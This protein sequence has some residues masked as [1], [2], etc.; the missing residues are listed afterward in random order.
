MDFRRLV[1]RKLSVVSESAPWKISGKGNPRET[2]LNYFTT[3]VTT[4]PEY[5]T[6]L[7]LAWSLC[8]SIGFYYTRYI[9]VTFYNPP[10][11]P[12]ELIRCKK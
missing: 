5:W 4:H 8:Q 2:V 9:D 6:K 12:P 11:Y 1:C 7:K 3:H 10:Y